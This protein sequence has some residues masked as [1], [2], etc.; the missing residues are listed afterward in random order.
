MKNKEPKT[1]PRHMRGEMRRAALENKEMTQ[2]RM[3]PKSYVTMSMGGMMIV[4]TFMEIA[5]MLGIL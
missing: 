1:S 4:E 3:E 5:C 2:G